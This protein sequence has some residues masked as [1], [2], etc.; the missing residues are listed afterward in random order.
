MKINPISLPTPFYIGPVNVYLH[1]G[2]S[3]TI[4]DTGRRL[5]SRRGF[6]SRIAT[7]GPRRFRYSGASCSRTAPRRPCGMARALR[8]EAKDAEVLVHGWE[9]RPSRWS[10]RIDEEHRQL[11]VRAGVPRNEVEADASSYDDVR[12]YADSLEEDHVG[13]LRDNTELEFESGA[14]RV[15]HTPGHIRDRARS[16]VKRIAR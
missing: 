15:V 11:L 3:I 8:D 12:Q 6:E 16:C 1:R 4:I 13:E 7:S 9:N 10:P 14:L 2:R 5:K